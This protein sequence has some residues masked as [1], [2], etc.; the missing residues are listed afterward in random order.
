M[1]TIYGHEDRAYRLSIGQRVY[2][3]PVLYLDQDGIDRIRLG[4]L[5]IAC[6]EP[7]EVPF[8]TECAQPA[9]RFPMERFQVEVF[10]HC[11]VGVIRIGPQTSLSD[12]M[13]IMR[14][15]ALRRQRARDG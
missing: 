7:H 9:C 2:D 3:I 10:E 14:E 11:Y 1:P 8:P 6:L 15:E 12:E 4:Y 5:C 13:E